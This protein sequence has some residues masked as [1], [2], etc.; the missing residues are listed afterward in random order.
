MNILPRDK[1]KPG[2]ILTE[3]DYQVA[4]DKAFRYALIGLLIPILE[5][6]VFRHA[7]RARKSQNPEIQNKAQ[8]AI[9]IAT[10]VFFYAVIFPLIVIS[11]LW[12]LFSGIIVAI[13]LA[14]FIYFKRKNIW[15]QR[16]IIIAIIAITLFLAYGIFVSLD[17]AKQEVGINNLNNT[18]QE[19]AID[20]KNLSSGETV[21]EINR[22]LPSAQIVAYK[23]HSKLG[24]EVSK[25]WIE[26]LQAANQNFDLAFQETLPILISKGWSEQSARDILSWMTSKSLIILD[27]DPSWWCKSGDCTP[28]S[29]AEIKTI[30]REDKSLSEVVISGIFQELKIDNNIY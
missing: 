6:E 23:Q 18:M 25:I 20:F 27:R 7:D 15:P 22:L 1:V 16:K 12:N 19:V 8:Q 10:G 3:Q 5:I 13:S 24:N 4:A 14:L 11:S 29:D 9:N 21:N 30:L 26:N 17:N 2:Q 28:K